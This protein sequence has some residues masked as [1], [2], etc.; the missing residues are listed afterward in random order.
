MREIMPQKII[1]T[2][3]SSIIGK[4]FD[5]ETMEREYARL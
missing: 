5:E 2:L 3:K 1:H 4:S